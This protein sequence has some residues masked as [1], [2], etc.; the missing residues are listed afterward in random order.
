MFLF[1][2]TESSRF[3]ILTFFFWFGWG[4]YEYEL[5]PQKAT[6]GGVFKAITW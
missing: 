6:F 4:E 2:M 3:H 5:V 1:L